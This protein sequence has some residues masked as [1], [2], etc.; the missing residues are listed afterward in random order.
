MWS[1]GLA[2]NTYTVVYENKISFVTPTIFT[3]KKFQMFWGFQSLFQ[4]LKVYLFENK[5]FERE[6][7][8]STDYWEWRVV[9]SNY[10]SNNPY[11]VLYVQ[12]VLVQYT[13]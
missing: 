4:M 12:Y 6:L 13:E 7:N 1:R 5:I 9:R 10:I 8:T 2:Q 11:T 3:H